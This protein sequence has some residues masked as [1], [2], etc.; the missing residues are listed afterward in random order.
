MVRTVVEQQQ[1]SLRRVC[2]VVRQQRA[3]VYAKPKRVNADKLISEQLIALSVKYLNWAG[4]PLR[5][6]F[7]VWLVATGWT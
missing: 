6:R 5:V 1:A 4:P 3:T 7:D 2:R